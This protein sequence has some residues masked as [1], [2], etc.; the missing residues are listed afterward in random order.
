MITVVPG[1][2]LGDLHLVDDVSPADWIVGSVHDFGAHDVGTLLPP[3]LDAYARLFHPANKRAD[4]CGGV[5][6][7]WAE[8]AAA[9]DRVAHGGM[10]WVAITGGWQYLHQE[11]QPGIWDQEP[12]EGSLPLRLAAALAAV[13]GSFTAT[14]DRCWFAVWDGSGGAAWPSRTAA[15]VPMPQRPMGLFTGPLTGVMT[16][17]DRAPFDQRASLWWPDDHRWC[18]ATDVDLMTT[19]VG[20]SA[21]CIEAVLVADDLEAAAVTVDQG[22]T[23]DSDTVNPRPDPPFPLVG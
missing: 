13:L 14:A 3:N 20:G 22:V 18:V 23:W 6:V 10:E 16:S 19:Y 5:E 9:N 2:R 7:R 4:D 8:V 15:K 12:S 17:F 1:F 21:A 11:S